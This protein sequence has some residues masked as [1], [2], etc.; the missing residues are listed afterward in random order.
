MYSEIY[1]QIIVFTS[2]MCI[3]NKII[4]Y[5]SVVEKLNRE[6]GGERDYKT[7][8]EK[9]YSFNIF[10]V[11]SYLFIFLCSKVSEI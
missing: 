7:K 6:K 9:R 11:N 1:I 5:R 4:T 2:K 10:I 3:N 8:L